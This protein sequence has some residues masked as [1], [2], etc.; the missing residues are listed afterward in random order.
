M[1]SF[2]D[3]EALDNSGRH[4]GIF[5][6][7]DLTAVDI[8]ERPRSEIIVRRNGEVIGSMISD[9]GGLRIYSKGGEFLKKVYNWNAIGFKELLKEQ[10]P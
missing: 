10:T 9:S 1:Y 2:N 5:K 6:H 4:S 3:C 8:G 7:K